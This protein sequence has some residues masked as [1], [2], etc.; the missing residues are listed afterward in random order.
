MTKHLLLLSLIASSLLSDELESIEVTTG[1]RTA[2]MLSEA[3]IKTEIVTAKEIENT[4]ARDVSDA[5]KN[6][7][8]LMIKET[9]GKQGQSVWIQGFNSDRVLILIDGEPM[10]SSMGQT[11]D[12]SQ[13][14]TSDIK[15]IEILK[16]AASA[17]YGSQAMGGVINIKTK[18]PKEGLHN[19]VGVEIGTYGNKSP[20]EKPTTLLSTSSSYK[21]KDYFVS[22]H[23]DYL[24]DSGVVLDDISSYD[25]P[26]RKRVNFNAEYRTLGKHQFYIRPRY[27]YEDSYKPFTS[28]SPGIGDVDEVREEDVNKFRLSLGSDSELDNMD[29]VK[30]SLFAERYNSNSYQ[31]KTATPYIESSRYATIDLVQ[32][33]VQ[34]DTTLSDTHLLTMGMQARY[35]ALDQSTKKETSTG[36]Q[37]NDEMVGK[38]SVYAIEGYVQDDWFIADN[39]ELLPGLRYQY[40]N[41]F[42]SYVSPKLSLFYTPHQDGRDRFNIRLSYGNGYRVPGIKERYYVFDQSQAGVMLI[43]NPNLIPETSHSYQFSMEYLS[44]HDYSLAVNLYYNDIKNL[45]DLKKNVPLSIIRGLQMYEY[46]NVDEAYT[47]GFEFESSIKFFQ[48]YSL[49]GGYT[50]LYAKD[51]KTK[52]YLTDRPEHQFK[53]TFAYDTKKTNAQISLNYESE[54]YVDSDNLLKSPAQTLIDL[55]VTR[56]LSDAWNIYA[57]VNNLL[58]EF[59]NVGDVNDVGSNNPRYY[60]VGTNYEF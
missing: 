27:Y 12:L 17:L 49:N 33:E 36:S 7:P 19:K 35:N 3:P 20:N 26:Q 56:H 5:I 18:S 11:V 46:E 60:F 53:T 21:N 16:G 2:K 31:N 59:R 4:H 38:A 25:L 24:Y 57:G 14:S 40:D 51:K 22:A 29:R 6:I 37:T 34:F 32:G 43:G 52:K 41:D 28:F 10:T 44:S 58:D 1:T 23:L 55:R 47:T 39:L 30:T 13:L 50:Y 42:G 8:G 54:Q 9:H 48:N 15:S 45:I